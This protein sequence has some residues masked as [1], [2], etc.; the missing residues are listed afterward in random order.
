MIIILSVILK[1]KSL[2]C[3]KALFGAAAND[4]EEQSHEIHNKF[5]APIKQRAIREG[6][7]I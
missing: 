7:N 6:E 3:L 2:L 5:G 4:S 1:Y